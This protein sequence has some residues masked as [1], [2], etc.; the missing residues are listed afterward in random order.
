MTWRSILVFRITERQG[1]SLSAD[2]G[3]VPAFRE[4]IA[5]HV[6]FQLEIAAIK[7]NHFGEI[8]NPE[9]LDDRAVILKGVDRVVVR[10][11]EQDTGEVRGCR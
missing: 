8:R 7:S 3:R 6:L 1:G 2:T 5:R 9:L 11:G 10:P 4:A